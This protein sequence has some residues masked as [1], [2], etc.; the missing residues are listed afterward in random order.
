MVCNSSMNRITWP[1][2]LA[3]SF[4]T[5]F[6]R[7]SNSP[8]NLAPAINAAMSSDSSC[9]PL[10]PSG[11]SPLTIR[12]AKPSTIAVL[13]TP[14]S[15]INTGLFLVRR[16]RTWMVRRISSSRPITGSSL[17]CSARSVRLMVYFFRAWRWSSALASLTF[18]PPR[19]FSMAF[20]TADAVTP[21][22]FNSFCKAPPVSSAANTN[23]SLEIKASL[24][25][26]ASL[27]VRF[28]IRDSSL[29]ICTSPPAPETL[30][31][32]SISLLS[33]LRNALT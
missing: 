24:R 2:S 28:S 29:E 4:N 16:C 9:L 25:F 13:P 1:S 31:K 3:T 6:K 14:G 21:A 7:S 19:I 18:C 22:C 5:A 23:S 10:I 33:S 26:C 27:S 15:P 11:T 8:R 20:S 17:P 12:C 30:A 32:R